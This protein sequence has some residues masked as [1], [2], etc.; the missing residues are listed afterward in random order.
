VIERSDLDEE[1]YQN[2]IKKELKA[3]F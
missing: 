1:N 2:E 3:T